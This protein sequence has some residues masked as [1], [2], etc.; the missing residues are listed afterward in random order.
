MVIEKGVAIVSVIVAPAGDLSLRIDGH[1]GASRTAESAQIDDAAVM[2]KQ[3]RMHRY[4]FGSQVGRQ[5]RIANHVAA[6]VDGVGSRPRDA[7]V[8]QLADLAVGVHKGDLLVHS[9]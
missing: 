6:V 8:G 5:N 4:E 7:Q 3:R 2:W 1:R 9:L